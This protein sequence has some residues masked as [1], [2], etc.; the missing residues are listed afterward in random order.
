[1]AIDGL[2]CG[3]DSIGNVRR[4]VHF[5]H[6]IRMAARTAF[7]DDTCRSPNRKEMLQK[8]HFHPPKNEATTRSPGRFGPVQHGS[9][10]IVTLLRGATRW[11]GFLPSPGRATTILPPPNTKKIHFPPP[12]NKAAMRS[13]GRF[14]S[15]QRGH[16]LIVMFSR[17][18]TR[19]NGFIPSRGREMP[20]LSDPPQTKKKSI[21]PI[22]KTKPPRDPLVDFH[23]PNAGTC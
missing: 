8:L 9:S 10:L 3:M 17:C 4:V 18:S 6:I 20:R 2:G 12:Q 23:R 14:R 13:P 19:W 16:F 5:A 21:F 1:M 15:R 22:L 11:N 7:L